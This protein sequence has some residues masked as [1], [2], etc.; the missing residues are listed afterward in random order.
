MQFKLGTA[1]ALWEIIRLRSIRS[2]ERLIRKVVCDLAIAG[3]ELRHPMNFDI[4]HK[5]KIEPTIEP[6]VS[7]R[8]HA[9]GL[10]GALRIAHAIND[11]LKDADAKRE[12]LAK[13][14]E[15]A[16]AWAAV[17]LGNGNDEYLER[18]MLDTLHLNRFDAQIR[19]GTRHVVRLERS[20]AHYKL[21]KA[22]LLA[23]FPE[24]GTKDADLSRSA[25]DLR[26]AG[27]FWHTASK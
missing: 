23:G 2:G 12:V 19:E 1:D 6:P 25:C 16:T 20:I 14:I 22:T 11:A 27:S 3:G 15:D 21:L 4:F 26:E 18:E 7:E 13:E 8:V 17:T 5:S 24:L 9:P 10:E